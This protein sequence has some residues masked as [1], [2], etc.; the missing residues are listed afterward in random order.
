[1]QDP[2]SAI[3]LGV[4]PPLAFLFSWVK[5]RSGFLR[6]WVNAEFAVGKYFGLFSE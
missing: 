6:G 2:L 5:S 3:V 4:C 1:M